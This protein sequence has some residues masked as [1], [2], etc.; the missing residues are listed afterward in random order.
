MIYDSLKNGARY[1]YAAKDLEKVFEFLFTLTENTPPGRYE[2]S[3]NAY[4]ILSE[5]M[6]KPRAEG[7][8]EA[9]EVYAD[10][11]YMIRGCE[12]LDLCDGSA[13]SVTDTSAG[14]DLCFF[15]EP[16]AYSS[17]LL[18]AGKFVLLYPGEA[19]KP[20]TAVDDCPAPVRK[21]VAK[22]RMK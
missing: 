8:F 5:G 14:N 22:I 9:H 2:I 1:L 20:L 21:A 6:T 4:V 13:L 10:V 16:A 15:S 19:H 12:Y 7:R 3:E 17:L 11:Q 18:E